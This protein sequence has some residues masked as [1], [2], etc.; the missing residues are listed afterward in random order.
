M[1]GIDENKEIEEKKAEETKPSLDKTLRVRKLIKNPMRLSMSKVLE[2]FEPYTL[3]ELQ[4]K[5]KK[6]MKH[7][8]MLVKLKK[9]EKV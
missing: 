6:F 7:I 5:D 3:T 1:F 9:I 4:L 8:N 2:N